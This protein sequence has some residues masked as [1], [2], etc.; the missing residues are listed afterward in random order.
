MWLHSCWWHKT[1]INL[2]YL[3]DPNKL[4]ILE[5]IQLDKSLFQAQSLK[6]IWI[7]MR[8]GI[9]PCISP[10]CNFSPSLNLLIP[11]ITMFLF[12]IL[13]KILNNFVWGNVLSY[14]MHAHVLSHVQ[15]LKPYGVYSPLGSS[16]DGIF[17][18]RV[19]GVDCHSLLQGVFWPSDWIHVSWISCSA[20]WILYH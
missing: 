4:C 7:T 2:V 12:N 18:A 10:P 14:L 11:C 8:A 6:M 20:R 16:V 5:P 9:G 15:L 3:S 1:V 19:L 13:K 17:Q